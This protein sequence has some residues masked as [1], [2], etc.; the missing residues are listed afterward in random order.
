MAK[1]WNVL[2]IGFA[3]LLS[4]C[5]GTT[6]QLQQGK[7]SFEQKNYT[8]AFSELKPAAERGNKDAQYAIGYMY[9]Y[10][11]GVQK[12]KVAAKKWIGKAAAQ[13]QQQAIKAQERLN[14]KSSVKT[15]PLPDEE[16]I[17]PD[18]AD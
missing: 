13:G 14:T 8:E 3:L 17:K 11:R 16:P 9:F 2:I 5:A 12:N 18:T 1:K 10:G 4:A 7:V 15:T 6:K